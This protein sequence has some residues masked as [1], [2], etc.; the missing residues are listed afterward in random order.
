MIFDTHTLLSEP[1]FSNTS[2][3]AYVRPSNNQPLQPKYSPD[4]IT[5]L[6]S[7][8]C[9][10]LAYC[11]GD[12]SIGLGSVATVA[13]LY[14]AQSWFCGRMAGSRED[15]WCKELMARLSMK[16]FPIV[17]VMRWMP[18]GRCD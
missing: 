13:P 15:L 7:N 9:Q 18:P 5:V 6:A 16:G 4:S 11:L 17:E 3:M 10:S 2:G 8:I 14:S 1:Y 12:E